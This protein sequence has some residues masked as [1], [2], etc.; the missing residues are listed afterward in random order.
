MEDSAARAPAWQ[1]GL[2]PSDPDGLR[3][4]AGIHNARLGRE[5]CASRAA[6]AASH[7]S[8]AGARPPTA[9]DVSRLSTGTRGGRSKD[10]ERN[11]FE[12]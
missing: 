7:L 3:V 4:W 12:G 9:M 11:V 6:S 10:P 8:T 1:G 2:P 5:A